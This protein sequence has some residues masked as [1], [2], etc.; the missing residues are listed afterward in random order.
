MLD[1][2]FRQKVPG[3]DDDQNP[4]DRGGKGYKGD[5]TMQ[6]VTWVRFA[7]PEIIRKGRYGGIVVVSGRRRE[8]LWKQP[9]RVFQYLR[10]W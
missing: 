4:L 2:C 1:I 3:C 9:N 10:W 8:S 7:L 6:M 5:C